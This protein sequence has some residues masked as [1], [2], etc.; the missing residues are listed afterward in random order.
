MGLNGWNYSWQITKK[1]W[2]N[3]YIPVSYPDPGPLASEAA[4]QMIRFN[5][6]R[7]LSAKSADLFA[8]KKYYRK[9]HS[10]GKRSHRCTPL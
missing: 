3:T 7:F 1:K 8:Q 2:K 6:F 10:N 4:D 9:F 5:P